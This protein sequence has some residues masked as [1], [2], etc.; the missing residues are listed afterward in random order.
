L[1]TSIGAWSSRAVRKVEA[2]VCRGPGKPLIIETLDLEEPREHEILVRGVA[3][4]MCNTDILV[5][6][7]AGTAAFDA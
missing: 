7:K 2:V 6:A 5:R 1:R 3:T 4:G